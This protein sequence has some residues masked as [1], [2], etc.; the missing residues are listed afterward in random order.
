MTFDF[1]QRNIQPATLL[2]IV[3]IPLSGNVGTLP[4]DG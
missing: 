1:P 2:W 4:Q 3:E